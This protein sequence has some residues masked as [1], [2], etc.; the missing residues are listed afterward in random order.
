MITKLSSTTK[1]QPNFR[2]NASDSR[3][4]ILSCSL[5]L[6]GGTASSF[7][8][9]TSVDNATPTILSPASNLANGDYNWWINCSDGI[10]TN[11]SEKRNISIN[12]NDVTAPQ[13]SIESPDN[14]TINTTDNTPDFR[15]NV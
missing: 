2:F 9:N 8:T 5:W 10:N 15:F 13:I 12:I 1:R 4:T 11:I 3:V 14:N 6:D 7:A